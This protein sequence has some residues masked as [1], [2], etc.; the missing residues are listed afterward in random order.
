MILLVCLR[1][2]SQCD[3]VFSSTSTTP[4]PV[5]P[6]Q[7]GQQ[8]QM[9]HL[10]FKAANREE[11]QAIVQHALACGARTADEQFSDSWV[12]MIDPEG[13]PFCIDTL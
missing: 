5:W 11:M 4:P 13:H 8:Q 9:E 1:P 12:V 6:E 7:V 10:D 3:W 2:V